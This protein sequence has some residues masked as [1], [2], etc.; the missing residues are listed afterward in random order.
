M[1][2]TDDACILN[3]MGFPM[4]LENAYA[5]VSLL[6]FPRGETMQEGSTHHSQATISLIDLGAEVAKS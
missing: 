4:M 6:H 5:M 2:P 3:V 1:F